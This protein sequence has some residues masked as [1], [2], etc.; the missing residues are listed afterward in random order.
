MHNETSSSGQG[1]KVV[2]GGGGFTMMMEASR[3]SSGVSWTGKNS[4]QCQ[5]DGFCGL[6]LKS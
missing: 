2:K 5:Y 3:N 4:T 6:V 1:G